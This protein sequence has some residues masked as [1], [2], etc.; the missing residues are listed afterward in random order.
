MFD[1][2]ITD[3]KTINLNAKLIV[4]SNNIL[5]LQMMLIFL[6]N[7]WILSTQCKK[8]YVISMIKVKSYTT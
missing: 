3:L 5:R 7:L 1:K 8:S 4:K 6:R 2:K